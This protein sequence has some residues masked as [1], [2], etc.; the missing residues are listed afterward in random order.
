MSETGWRGAAKLL[1]HINHSVVTQL[2]FT[3]ILSGNGMTI[4]S[5]SDSCEPSLP[6]SG[7]CGENGMLCDEVYSA[8]SVPSSL[9][10]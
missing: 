8:D 7:S 10:D 2:E 9:W 1:A 6:A 3:L 5:L 4:G